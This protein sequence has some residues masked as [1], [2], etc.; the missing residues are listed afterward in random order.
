[1]A[2]VKPITDAEEARFSANFGPNSPGVGKCP[3]PLAWGSCEDT[4]SGPYSA[5][6]RIRVHVHVWAKEL[7]SYTEPGCPANRRPASEPAWC[8]HKVHYPAVTSPLARHMLIFGPRAQPHRSNPLNIA[9]RVPAALWASLVLA[10]PFLDKQ[11]SV[12]II[13]DLSSHYGLLR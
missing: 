9:I 12:L 2:G 11:E 6:R 4:L 7:T 5:I 3:V 1:M 10:Y 13:C 8:Q